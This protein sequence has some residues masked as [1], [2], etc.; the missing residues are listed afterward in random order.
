MDED[1]ANIKAFYCLAD[2]RDTRSNS[3]NPFGNDA[4]GDDACGGNGHGDD[5]ACACDHRAHNNQ[6]LSRTPY[7]TSHT[8]PPTSHT[9]Y[10]R[11]YGHHNRGHTHH[12]CKHL[13]RS[14]IRRRAIHGHTGLHVCHSIHRSLL[15]STE[16]SE[17]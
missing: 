12:D 1:I 14:H 11:N 13:C 17:G 9:A 10:D 4:C 3:H 2:Y 6:T 15:A 8:H 7:P 5:G 16:S